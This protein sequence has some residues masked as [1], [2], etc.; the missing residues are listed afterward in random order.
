MVHGMA[1]VVVHGI[2]HVMVHGIAHVMVHVQITI[3]F[4]VI[5]IFIHPFYYL[6][7]QFLII[8]ILF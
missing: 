7:C 1:H 2:A 5:F 8:E 4:M 6:N 3:Y